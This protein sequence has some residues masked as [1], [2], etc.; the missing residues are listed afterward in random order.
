MEI[1]HR[2]AIWMLVGVLLLATW[3]I[4]IIFLISGIIMVQF[5]ALFLMLYGA[6]ITFIL[7]NIEYNWVKVK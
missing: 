6:I 3:G 5:V 7:L 4:G 1:G 2:T